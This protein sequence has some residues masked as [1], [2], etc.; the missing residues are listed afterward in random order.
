MTSITKFISIYNLD[1]NDTI[2]ILKRINRIVPEFYNQET[3]EVDTSRL[4]SP[5]DMLV[6]LELKYSLLT[7]INTIQFLILLYKFYQPAN[8]KELL[9]YEDIENDLLSIYENPKAYSKMSKGEIEEFLE[10][11][12]I[13]FTRV[14][15]SYTKV[16]NLL[17]LSLVFQYPLK[18]SEIVDMK[19]YSYEG[20]SFEEC[21]PIPVA[22]YKRNCEFYIVRNG[23][24]IIE[25]KVE[26]ITF[27][28]LHRTLMLYLSKFKRGGTL[29]CGITGGKLTKSNISNGLVNFTRSELGYPLSIHDIKIYHSIS[30]KN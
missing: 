5:K 30:L 12:V 18:L 14:G 24:T 29:F 16:R 2:N 23:K 22:I 6:L 20:A 8:S 11:K 17:L 21:F 10:V 1:Y 7:N 4:Q 15:T 13:D 19:Y 3:Q 27:T 28:P 9:E 26:K 25:Q